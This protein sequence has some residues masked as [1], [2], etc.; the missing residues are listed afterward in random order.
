[1]NFNYAMLITLQDANGKNHI[2]GIENFF[3]KRAR[4]ITSKRSEAKHKNCDL[5]CYCKR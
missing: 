3:S 2:N 4:P 5:R 1:M